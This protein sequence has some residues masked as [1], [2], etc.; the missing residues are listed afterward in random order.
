MP[1]PVQIS[2]LSPQ[3]R[4]F[5]RQADQDGNQDGRIDSLREAVDT[6]QACQD[7]EVFARQADQEGNRNGRIDSLIEAKAFARR[8]NVMINP[9]SIG[10]VFNAIQAGEEVELSSSVLRAE[11]QPIM[12]PYFPIISLPAIEMGFAL[13]ADANQDELITTDE[14]NAAIDNCWETAEPEGFP[15]FG[16]AW[17]SEI[18]ALFPQEAQRT[19]FEGLMPLFFVDTNDEI[20]IFSPNILEA[21][22]QEITRRQDNREEYEFLLTFR[23]ALINYEVNETHCFDMRDRLMQV[24]YTPEEWREIRR[25]EGHQHPAFS[26]DSVDEAVVALDYALTAESALEPAAYLGSINPPYSATRIALRRL[27]EL[28]APFQSAAI[29]EQIVQLVSLLE[30]PNKD[31][32]IAAAIALI[33]TNDPRALNALPVIER[34]LNHPN[35]AERIFILLAL[36]DVPR[37]TNILFIRL[38]NTLRYNQFHNYDLT[39]EQSTVLTS[40][41]DIQDRLGLFFINLEDP[42]ASYPMFR[43]AFRPD[44]EEIIARDASEDPDNIYEEQRNSLLSLWI[45]ANNELFLARRLAEILLNQRI[46]YPRRTPVEHPGLLTNC[47]DLLSLFMVRLDQIPE[48]LLEEARASMAICSTPADGLIDSHV[49][50]DR[51]ALLQSNVLRGLNP[52]SEDARLLTFLSIDTFVARTLPDGAM[53]SLSSNEEIL[54]NRLLA[55]VAHS[56]EPRVIGYLE[57]ILERIHPHYREI[58][59]PIIDTLAIMRRRLPSVGTDATPREEHRGSSLRRALSG[60]RFEPNAPLTLNPIE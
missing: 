37:N 16:S 10:E 46:Q 15:H 1:E 34:L 33:R 24:R 56:S 29:E 22:D 58:R 47:P 3:Y 38:Q 7:A 32:Q 20:L 43:L 59:Q 57:Q 28:L 26:F 9:D 12:E 45:N 6:I 31:I 4:A 50:M 36:F 13:Q 5:A 39:V 49:I 52:Y 27:D 19:A 8:A 51:E 23:S 54:L 41:P 53:P 42:K 30:D 40:V 44:F 21:L 14:A 55:I 35:T 25:H 17:R 48:P 18:L 2:S 11:L 60:W